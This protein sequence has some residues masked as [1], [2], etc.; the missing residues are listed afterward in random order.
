MQIGIRVD[1]E[2]PINPED[3]SAYAGELGGIG[4]MIAATNALCKRFQ[5]REGTVMHGVDNDAALSNCFGP[6]N[7]NTVLSHCQTNL[8][9]DQNV[10]DKMDREKG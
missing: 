5:I 8:S 9:S 4:G 6:F 1:N 2:I 10:T 3:T 7:A